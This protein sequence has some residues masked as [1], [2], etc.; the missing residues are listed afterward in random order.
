[1]Q[2]S[3][4]SCDAL[5]FSFIHSFVLRPFVGLWPPLQFRNHLYTDGR[6]PWV[7]GR[8]IS[9]SQGRYLY[10]GQHKHK[11]NAHIDIHALSGI[12]TH[13]PSVRAGEDGSCLRPRGLCDRHVLP[14][15]PDVLPSAPCS[16]T[17]ILCSLSLCERLN[18]KTI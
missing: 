2:F 10:T 14:L 12:R 13:D 4:N 11:V 15:G 6:T 9:P 18:F 3:L 8:V 7:L 16:L 17:Y 5:L 1:M